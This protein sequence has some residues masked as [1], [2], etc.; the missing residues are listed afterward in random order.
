MA[1]PNGAFTTGKDDG[2]VRRRNVQTYD[3][4]NG[5][6]VYKIEAEDTKKLQKVS[7]LEPVAAGELSS[8]ADSAMAAFRPHRLSR[9]MGVC[10]RTPDLHG[11]RF[12]YANVAD[13]AITYRH[14]GRSSVSPPWQNAAQPCPIAAD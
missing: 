7:S 12:F 9:R 1:A 5:G 4:A 11:A 6:T 14:L 3:K 2:D 10:D 13:R 8:T